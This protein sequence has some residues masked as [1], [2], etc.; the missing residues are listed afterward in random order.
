[1]LGEDGVLRVLDG[2]L[3][4]VWLAHQLGER[5]LVAVIDD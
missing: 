1:M 3:V 5:L 4:Q 2:L